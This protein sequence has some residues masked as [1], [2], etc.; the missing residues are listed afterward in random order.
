MLFTLCANEVTADCTGI[1]DLVLFA[2]CVDR[3]IESNRFNGNK[4]PS[5]LLLLLLQFPPPPPRLLLVWLNDGI[6]DSIVLA[7]HAPF[8]IVRWFSISLA[9]LL[10][11]LL[12]FI[13]DGDVSSDMSITFDS[14]GLDWFNGARD[15]DNLFCRGCCC[16]S[17]TGCNTKDESDVFT[18]VS[19]IE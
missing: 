2:S 10:L 9:W 7:A 11:W 3:D 8:S 13:D 18:A 19:M 1:V 16:S 15:R 17:R 5:F 14:F 4:L 6:D 12:L